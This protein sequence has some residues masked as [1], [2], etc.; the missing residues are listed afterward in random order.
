MTVSAVRFT[1]GAAK[2]GG[3]VARAARRTRAFVRLHLGLDFGGGLR[4]RHRLG[5]REAFAL[6]LICALDMYT[7]LG[8]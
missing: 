5:E 7:T 4:L 1:G 3:M 8:G 6:A 2:R